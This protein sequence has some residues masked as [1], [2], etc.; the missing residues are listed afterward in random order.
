M[1]NT[2]VSKNGVLKLFTSLKPSK[3]AGPDGLHPTVL[4]KVAPVI[5]LT[6]KY[7]DSSSV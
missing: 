6:L 3:A 7:L 1:P 5:T 4:K 2:Q